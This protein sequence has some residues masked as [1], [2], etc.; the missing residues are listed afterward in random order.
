MIVAINK[1]GLTSKVL[2]VSDTLFLK[3]QGTDTSIKE[4]ANSIKKIF[5]KH[6]SSKFEF[7]STQQQADELWEN[8]KYALMSTIAAAGDSSKV[9]T[10]DVWYVYSQS[11]FLDTPMTL[12]QLVFLFPGYLN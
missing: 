6:G 4:T 3:L 2:P 9:W 11:S 7:A 10:T 5:Q 12:I 8:R 1:A